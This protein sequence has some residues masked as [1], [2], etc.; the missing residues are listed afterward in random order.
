MGVNIRYEYHGFTFTWDST[1]AGTN[2]K[3]HGV[4]FE[5][6]CAAVLNEIQVMERADE[7]GE[8]RWAIIAYARSDRFAGPLYVIVVEQGDEAWRIIS[9]R[10]ATPQERKRYEE[11]INSY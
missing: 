5:E 7:E 4:S 9:A 6:A 8:Q 1:K 2:F 11:E 3:K 10:G